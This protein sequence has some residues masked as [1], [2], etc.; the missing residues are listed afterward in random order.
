MDYLERA[1]FWSQEIEEFKKT[2]SASVNK[3]LAEDRRRVEIVTQLKELGWTYVKELDSDLKYAILRVEDSNQEEGEF[4]LKINFPDKF[5]IEPFKVETLCELELL[6]SARIRDVYHAYVQKIDQFRPVRQIFEGLESRTRV[7]EAPF[8]DQ[9]IWT[10]MRVIAI[11]PG[12][13][14]EITIDPDSFEGV[15]KFLFFGPDDKIKPLMRK[16]TDDIDDYDS[17]ESL[18]DNLEKILGTDYNDNC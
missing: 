7:I 12:I 11:A 1:K 17:E 15:P 13:C 2:S 6:K 4:P 16:I 14:L 8:P 9:A 18:A 3:I 5:P 10:P